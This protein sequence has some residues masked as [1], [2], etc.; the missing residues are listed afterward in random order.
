MKAKI[1]PFII[2]IAIFAASLIMGVAAGCSIGES[3]PQ[4][5]ANNRGMY[6]SVT[7]YANGGKFT[8]SDICYKTMYFLPDTPIFNIG[9]DAHPVGGSGS[10]LAV[11]R[12]NM[13]LVGWIKAE[14]D[15]NGNPTLLEMTNS[16][17]LTGK[18]LP[19][20]EN[21]SASIISS[22]DGRELSEQ[23]K[24]FTAKMPENP[25]NYQYVFGL[26]NELHPTLEEGEHWYLVAVWAPD[27]VLDYVLVADEAVT[28]EMPKVDDPDTEEDESQQTENR[29]LKT[30]DVITSETFG[31]VGYVTL[32]PAKAPKDA[33]SDHSFIYLFW[34]EECTLPVTS[35]NAH[36]GSQKYGALTVE[37]PQNGENAK[38][39]AKY[40]SGKG[41][42]TTVDEVGDVGTMFTQLNGS[43]NFYLVDDINCSSRTFTSLATG[44]FNGKIL[45]NGYTLSNLKFG[46]NSTDSLRIAPNN[47]DTVSL[48]GSLGETAEISDLTINNVTVCINVRHT[49]F[50][51]VYALFSSVADQATIENLSVEGYM[52]D[53][54][55]ASGDTG[56]DNIQLDEVTGT[57]N[58]TKWLYGGNSDEE[59]ISKHGNIITGAAL[60]IDNQTI[61]GQEESNE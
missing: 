22:E 49:Y 2:L 12:T 40:M 54:K 30:G 38:I 50:I 14:L 55:R 53:L 59:F 36:M 21:G 9:Y 46:T 37:R 51:S 43:N 29:E 52:L 41:K 35:K 33:E 19:M 17:E 18:T 61:I 10:D 5:S 25:D 58:T 34:D 7:Y 47:G 45:G 24:R 56:I 27:V 26:E 32:K 31:S 8:G 60:T 44:T 23:N 42:W 13:V 4:D 11:T 15:A 39:Y 48:F 3:T 28:F 16:G 6:S 1:K 57:Y 20:L